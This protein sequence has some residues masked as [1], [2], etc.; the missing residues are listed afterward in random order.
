M[1]PCSPPSTRT[2]CRTLF[3]ASLFVTLTAPVV[4]CAQPVLSISS[5][6][7]KLEAAFNWAREKA[8]SYVQTGKSGVVDRHERNS[9][10]TGDVPYI[11]SYWAGYTSRTAFYSRDYCHQA[12]GG[13]LLGL[14]RENLSMLKAFAATSTE[15]RKWFPLWALNFDGSAFKLDSPR[16]DYFVREVPAVFELVEQCYRQYLWTGDP[17]YLNDPTLWN[18][19]TK[20]VS[21]FIELHDTRIPNGVAEGD[22]SGDI[23]RGSATYNEVASDSPLIESGDAIACQYQALLSYSKML[24]LK[25]EGGKAEEF[26]QKATRLKSLFNEEW[27]VKKDST[28]YVRGY[29]VKG[30]APTNWGL[31]NSWFMPMKFITEPSERNDAFLDAIARCM[32]SRWGRPSNLEAITYIPGVF[33]PYN[34]VDEAWK[35]LEYIIDQ[36]DR[37]YPEVSYTL[38]GHVV[39]GMLGLEPNLPGGSFSTVSRLPDAVGSVEVSDIPLGDHRINVAHEGLTK[40]QVRHVSGGAPL[41]WEACFYGDHMKVSVNSKVIDAL[42]KKI[43]GLNA[44]FVVVDLPVGESATAE[45]VLPR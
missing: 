24:A 27:G 1:Y 19:C 8:L 39:E 5:S 18:F 40:S 30:N 21:E 44:C 12:T 32:D 28:G 20:A 4:A 11:P 36:P 16:D 3:L 14:Q 29:D 43:H 26:A 22:G 38:I 7:K 37:E 42:K 23:F 17:A 9:P 6:N 45:L 15:T 10:G 35:W 34:R 2:G 33:F 13:H 41:K 31:E 25:G